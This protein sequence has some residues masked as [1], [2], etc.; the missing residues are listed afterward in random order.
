[1][2]ETHALRDGVLVCVHT[3]PIQYLRSSKVRTKTPPYRNV[4]VRGAG[5]HFFVRPRHVLPVRDDVIRRVGTSQL[6]L[7]LS[8]R[9]SLPPLPLSMC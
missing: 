8:P 6:A 1:M 5:R 3:L 4:P 2:L 9:F 7:R